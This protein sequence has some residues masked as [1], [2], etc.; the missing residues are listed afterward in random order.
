MS[1]L[2]LKQLQE[3]RNSGRKGGKSTFLT[4]TPEKDRVEQEALKRFKKISNLAVKKMKYEKTGIQHKDLKKSL[5]DD[6]HED[7]RRKYGF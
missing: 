3:Q 6:L 7:S 2:F 5:F 1:D 4:E